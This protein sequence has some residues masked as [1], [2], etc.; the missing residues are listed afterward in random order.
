MKEAAEFEVF[1]NNEIIIETLSTTA[2]ITLNYALFKEIAE[3]DTCYSV[4]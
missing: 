2:T 4:I 3:N 1:N